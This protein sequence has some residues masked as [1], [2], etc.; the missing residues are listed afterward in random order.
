ME[1]FT[2]KV[3]GAQP[4]ETPESILAEEL[5]KLHQEKNRLKDE[6]AN[7]LSR[8]PE[9]QP[10]LDEFLTE[11]LIQKP[12]VTLLT[13]FSPIRTHTHHSF[14]LSFFEGFV[15]FWTTFLL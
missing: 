1:G 7:Y 10:L 2:P 6:N 12:N 3:A 15:S 14:T 8:H 9:L 5:E 4:N 11:V 13:S